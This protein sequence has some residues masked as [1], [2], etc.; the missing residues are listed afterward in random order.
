MIGA[1]ALASVLLVPAVRARAWDETGHMQIADIAWTRLTDK[2]KHEIGEILMA[3]DPITRPASM[4]DADVRAAFRKA[5]VFPDTIK[6]NKNTVYEDSI[7]A[8]NK[9]FFVT[10]PPNSADNED[11]RCKTWH[12]YDVA[13]R[14]KGSHAPKE[15][16]ALVALAKARTDLASL[17]AS[18]SSDR[19]L[20]CWWLTWIAHLAGDLHQP[21]HCVS[22]HETLP[23]GDAGG[24]LFMI[25]L[26]GSS[27]PGRLHGSWD[28]AITR[29]IADEKQQGMPA[30]FEEISQRWTQSY[31]PAP[32]DV[33]N[34]DAMAWVKSG[35]AL[36]DTVVYVGIEQDHEPTKGYETLQKDLSRRQAVLGGARLA[37]I[38]NDILSK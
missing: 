16:N 4:S 38:L 31:A 35:A 21:L 5:A 11:V 26:P 6:Y 37:A 29:A 33:A 18:G 8:M 3:G 30:A 2:A 7:D 28:G 15:S 14:D 25:K 36:S 32:A 23:D 13:I 10:H 34:V 1:L 24:N 27:R 19:K 12:Y 9:T 17:E 20:E 22:N